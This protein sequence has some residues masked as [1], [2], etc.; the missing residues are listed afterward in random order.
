VDWES[1][2]REVELDPEFLEANGLLKADILWDWIDA[3]QVEY[4]KAIDLP[5]A[6]EV[7]WL[8]Q[9]IY[10]LLCC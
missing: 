1:G 4:A 7:P 8:S 5:V 6:H 3:L 2:H 10:G 9:H